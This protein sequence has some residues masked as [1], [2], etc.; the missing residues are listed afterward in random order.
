MRLW[1]DRFTGRLT[2]YKLVIV[3]L[4]ALGVIAL[5]LSLLGQL[6]GIQPLALLASAAVAIVATNASN[7]AVARMLRITPHMDSAMITALLVFF[8]MDPRLDAIGLLSIAL[9]G[10]IATV[11]K[12]LI[13]VRGRHILNPA[14][15]G[16]FVVTVIAFAGVGDFSYARWWAG[17][18]YLL[19]PV[20]IAAFLIL[21]RTQRLAMG[22][23]FLAVTLGVVIVRYA[24]T[25]TPVVQA[26]TDT[27]LSGPAVFFVGFMLSEPLTLPPRRWQAMLEAVLVAL[28]MNVPFRLGI[29]GNSPQLALL[30]GNV[31]AFAF[32]QR[33]GITLTYLGKQQLSDTTWELSFQPDRPVRFSPGQYMELTIPHRRA[34]F[35]GSRRY[36]SVASAPAADAPITFAI[37][38]PSKSSSFKQALLD[39]EPG[40]VVRATSVGG[41]FVLPRDASQP[42]LLVAGGIGITPFASQLA[43]AAARGERRD[44]VVAYQTSSTGTPPYAS[45]LAES[46]ARVVLFAPEAPSPLPE[47]W[48]YGG[49]GRVDGQRLAEL[50][51]DAARRR[52]FISGPPALVADLRRALRGLGLRRVHTDAFSGY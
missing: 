18:P 16:V 48:Y 27:L 17:T 52:A 44:V 15:V 30:A 13:A 19:L 35:R 25:G 28:L 3:C 49:A 2:M 11:S 40:A 34:D 4:A 41:D 9:A 6:G 22:A 32:G 36:F 29:I 7:A 8:V 43:H 42:L 12:Y 39:L 33:R 37:T 47:G 26:V 5:A 50:V 45:V 51:P 10:V 21:Y 38:R 1:L 31:L 20:A 14:I 23:V 24:A 46:G